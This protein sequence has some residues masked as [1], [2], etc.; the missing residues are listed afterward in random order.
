MIPTNSLVKQIKE[1]NQDMEFYP[2][3]DEILDTVR[4][5]IH[6]NNQ[7]RHGDGV[8][9]Y[10][11][12]DC[13][14]GDGRVLRSIGHEH[15]DKYA[16]EKSTILLNELDKDTYVIGTDF[17]EATLIDKQVDIIFCNPPYS[18]YEQWASKIIQEANSK[19]IYLVIPDRW[20]NSQVITNAI[21]L[22]GL[23]DRVEVIGNFDFLNADRKARAHVDILHIKVNVDGAYNRELKTDPFD[24]WFDDNFKVDTKEPV[25]T[26]K[27]L[28]ED[29]KNNLVIS[30]NLI[31]TLVELYNQEMTD[32]NANFI[33]VTSLN[34][35]IL[36]EL[37][38]DVDSIKVA[39]KQRIK[40]L[41]NKYW[42]EL[43]GNY[44][45]INKKLTTKSLAR[46]KK[47]LFNHASVDFTASNCYAITGWVI[48][49][50]N[51][52]FDSQ[53]I[54]VVESMT[55]DCNIVNYKSNLRVFKEDGWRYTWHE[56]SKTLRDY[57]L[58]LR[59]IM[60]GQGGYYDGDFRCYDYINGLGKRGAT[61]VNDLIVVA[62]NLGFICDQR[63]ETMVNWSQCN[64]QNFITDN[65]DILMNVKAYK[66]E[67]LHIKFN[68]KL[69][70]KLN[71]EFGR[72]KGWLKDKQQAS[73]ELNIPI[74]DIEFYGNIRLGGSDLLML[75]GD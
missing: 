27:K 42:T 6:K 74:K 22:R 15:G 45:V 26:E 44:D 48:K 19:H 35:S 59:C 75:G 70:Q 1:N 54:D 20:R 65:G 40:G 67:N 5:S 69:I 46:M 37:S 12:L 38:V 21:T 33:A 73:E 62:N 16:I 66:N 64:N 23:T 17:Y 50:A 56:H 2:T 36:N 41:K 28:Q 18:E 71:V 10:S 53:L 9:S 51:G 30:G 7:S 34:A 47:R 25:N 61:T 13:G 39:L 32:L 52:Y 24:T 31:K 29:I 3:T 14:S 72:L 4:V 49:N 60:S 68:K 58:D 55:S 43:F 11:L 57:G 8:D 63:C